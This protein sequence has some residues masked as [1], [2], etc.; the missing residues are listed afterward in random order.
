MAVALGALGGAAAEA[1]MERLLTAALRE[2]R[3]TRGGGVFDEALLAA[4]HR[5]APVA[6]LAPLL[7]RRCWRSHGP[8]LA[9]AEAADGA[10]ADAVVAWLLDQGFPPAWPRH[11]PQ[12]EERGHREGVTNALNVA[13]RRGRLAM[14]LSLLS[15]GAPINEP[16]GAGYTPLMSALVT[17]ESESAAVVLVAAGADIDSVCLDILPWLAACQ[18]RHWRVVEAM[19]TL[20][21]DVPAC[22]GGFC[23]AADDGGAFMR[24]LVAHGAPPRLFQRLMEVGWAAQVRPA[25][26]WMRACIEGYRSGGRG[27]LADHL[28]SVLAVVAPLTADGSRDGSTATLAAAVAVAM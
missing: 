27:D 8:V 12:R 4:I 23:A 25:V 14:V 20:Y 9:S 2:A 5:G 11:L 10:Y 6:D 21:A 28:A 16:D 19:A 22:V 26:P 15:A 24:E 1:G 18:A 7:P 17:A 3:A 13:A